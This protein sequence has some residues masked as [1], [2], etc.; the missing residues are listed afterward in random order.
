[1][2]VAE[3]T[4]TFGLWSQV[5]A[6][7]VVW[8][9]TDEDAMRDLAVS[10]TGARDSLKK[11]I[12]GIEDAGT[13]SLLSW[14]EK[15]GEAYSAKLRATGRLHAVETKMAHLSAHTSQFAA[16]VGNTKTAIS[17]AIS[18]NVPLY[19]LTYALP[20]VIG[21]AARQMFAAQLATSINGVIDT[22]AAQIAA[23]QIDG[24]ASPQPPGG[25]TEG[26]GQ[27]TQDGHY[28]IGLPEKPNITFDEDFIFGSQ[29]P[30][31][32][33]YAT[34][35]KW[36][37]TVTGARVLGHLPDGTRMYEHYLG[38]TGDPLQFDLEKAY[39]EDSGIRAG[40]DTEIARAAAG[41]EEFIRAGNTNFSQTGQAS[42]TEDALYPTTENWQKAVGGYEG[43]WSHSN[44]RVDGNTVTMEIT[45]NAEDRYN[46]NRDEADIASGAPDNENGR[47]TEVGLAKPFDVHGEITRTV[48]WE[49][50]KPPAVPSPPM[51]GSDP[52]PRRGTWG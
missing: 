36:R 31:A 20:G 19:G 7:G 44:V 3:P 14:R 17:D 43:R 41:A 29:Q 6:H 50:G 5:K 26:A 32:A 35:A 16:D 22:M 13:T 12:A 24:S 30:T 9:D 33:D 38:Q 4:D 47:L 23:R 37:A 15:S 46:F 25:G 40:V 45:V 52:E 27:T 42:A 51:E 2:P 8:P 1:M 39:R 28:K 11:A 48:T 10:W 49:L 21:E 34:L 18:N